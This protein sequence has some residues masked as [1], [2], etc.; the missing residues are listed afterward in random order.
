MRHVLLA[1]ASLLLAAC[2][3]PDAPPPA[4]PAPAQPTVF[5]DQLRAIDRAEKVEDDVLRQQQEQDAAMEQQGG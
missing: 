3:G 1:F 5:D 2:A 4:Q